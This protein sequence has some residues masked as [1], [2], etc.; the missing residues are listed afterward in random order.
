MSIFRLRRALPLAVLFAIALVL[1]AGAARADEAPLK[2]QYVNLAEL[3]LRYLGAAFHP[4][5]DGAINGLPAPML[6]DTGSHATYLT[7]GAAERLDLALHMTGAR[8]NGIG[9]ASRVY[10][11]RIH[12]FAVARS[13]AAS[14]PCG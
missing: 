13:T 14:V 7:R 10:D 4:A 6:I 12:D 9:G 5:V 11:V 2:C 1:V 8:V 3:P